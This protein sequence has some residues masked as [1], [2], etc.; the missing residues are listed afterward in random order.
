MQRIFRITKRKKK[1]EE[2]EEE[3]SDSVLVGNVEDAIGAIGAINSIHATRVFNSSKTRHPTENDILIH[4]NNKVIYDALDRNLRLLKR[5][6]ERLEGSIQ[7]SLCSRCENSM[8]DKNENEDE[9]DTYYFAIHELK[10]SEICL[11]NCCPCHRGSCKESDEKVEVDGNADAD[12]DPI[13]DTPQSDQKT[14]KEDAIQTTQNTNSVEPPSIER[15]PESNP[16]STPIHTPAHSPQPTPSHS[17]SP[18]PSHTPTPPPPARSKTPSGVSPNVLTT[19]TMSLRDRLRER[20]EM[21]L[22]R[23]FEAST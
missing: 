19:P 6:H 22:A 20:K 11:S 4:E 14:R 7:L 1:R 16:K 21:R 17:P 9:D 8:D 15:A 18:S 12:I 23:K 10:R 2:E 13:K 5:I 3:D